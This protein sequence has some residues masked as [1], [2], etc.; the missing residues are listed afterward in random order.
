MENHSSG[1]KSDVSNLPLAVETR[2]FGS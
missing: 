1:H 2:I